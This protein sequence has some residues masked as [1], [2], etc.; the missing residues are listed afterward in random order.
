MVKGRHE[1]AG[2]AGIRGVELRRLARR[3]HV[4][5]GETRI[6]SADGQTPVA[7]QFLSKAAWRDPQI[8]IENKA[9]GQARIARQF[10]ADRLALSRIDIL[11]LGQGQGIGAAREV[12]N[13]TQ[14]S[15]QIG[16]R[17]GEAIVIG[18]R[19]I[20]GQI[21]DQFLIEPGIVAAV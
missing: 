10:L 16:R 9:G 14:K 3:V 12:A 5:A 13:L 20:A 6:V 21:V 11:A 18:R 4:R 19:R 2:D 17:A 8:S 1:G 15:R 7:Q